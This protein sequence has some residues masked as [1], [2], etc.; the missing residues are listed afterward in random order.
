MTL[1][2]LIRPFSK[3]FVATF[4]VAFL[5][6]TAAADTYWIPATNKVTGVGIPMA[7]GAPDTI[8]LPPGDFFSTGTQNE[9][10]ITILDPSGN[11]S[12][13]FLFENTDTSGEVMLGGPGSNFSAPGTPGS[14]DVVCT[15]GTSCQTWAGDWS[16][17]Q[18]VPGGFTM[19][20]PWGMTEGFRRFSIADA[21]G[22]N[23]DPFGVGY[24][25]SAEL[26]TA[27]PEPASLMMLGTGLLGLGG[28][29]RRHARRR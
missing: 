4:V 15:Q 6:T 8:Y 22:P 14:F 21:T 25:S 24:N 27:T 19:S 17:Y 20:W 2:N 18:V 29:L 1:V 9:G 28:V 26:M 16:Q 11:V 3:L 7:G 10:L 5:A 23:F 13:Q 12:A